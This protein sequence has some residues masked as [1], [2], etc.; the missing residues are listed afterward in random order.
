MALAEGGTMIGVQTLALTVADLDQAT[1]FFV[2]FFG[3]EVVSECG[4]Q[5]DTR[6]STMRKYSNVDV[7][8]V[9]RATRLLRTPF[10]NLSL[11]EATYPGQRALWPM[12]LDVGGWHLAGYVDDMDAAMEFLDRSDVYVLGPGKKPTTNAPEVGEGSFA[13][14]CMTAWGFHFELLTYPNGRAY[15]ADFDRR[16]WNPA[17]P[18]GGANLRVPAGRSVPGFRG[19][20][21]LSIAVADIEEVTSFLVDVIGCERFYDMGPMADPHGSDF[22]AY[23]NVDVRVDVS[24]VRLFRTPFLNLEVIEPE[25]PGQNHS[26]PGLLDVGGWRLDFSVDDIDALLDSVRQ[27]NI[28]VLGDKREQA[29]ASAE[30]RSW[31]VSCMTSFGF[32]FDLVQDD[33]GPAPAMAGVRAWHPAHPD[34]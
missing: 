14:H 6:G 23:A 31:R 16:L 4:R 10:L 18:D 3:A 1:E 11:A 20:E 2:S 32:Y 13:C 33:P 29:G 8:A 9:I 19:F 17:V 7:R 21:H 15:M 24:R 26:W 5:A 34:L 22:G 27:A 28:H 25:F 30:G 12:M